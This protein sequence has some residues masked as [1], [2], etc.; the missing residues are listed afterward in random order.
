MLIHY[1]QEC[2]S[3]E[4]AQCLYIYR[5]LTPC[6]LMFLPHSLIWHKKEKS[7]VP[8]VP[9]PIC[10]EHPKSSVLSRSNLNVALLSTPFPLQAAR[11][12]ASALV[13]NTP[14]SYL[15]LYSFTKWSGDPVIQ[16]TSSLEALCHIYLFPECDKE[17]CQNR[18]TANRSIVLTGLIYK[19]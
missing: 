8:R 11:L 9:L 3:R 15:L 10:L 6:S 19:Q 17:Q 5:S 12:E 14:T 18:T 16:S 13:C 2:L 1:I 7:T 4:S